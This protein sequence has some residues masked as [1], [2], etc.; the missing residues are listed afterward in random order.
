MI[1]RRQQAAAVRQSAVRP[2][3]SGC[4]S[5]GAVQI[6]FRTRGAVPHRIVGEPGNGP[7]IINRDPAQQVVRCS[8]GVSG[9]LGG[10]PPPPPPRRCVPHMILNHRS[11]SPCPRG[12]LIRTS[13]SRNAARG[14]VGLEP[15]STPTHGSH[16]RP[17]RAGPS[18]ADANH[19][20]ILVS[21][22]QPEIVSNDS[23]IQALRRRNSGPCQCIRRYGRAVTNFHHRGS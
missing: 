11:P 15:R 20:A 10:R 7:R 16:C 13:L 17:P 14:R 21:G 8:T 18:P 12:L 6:R 23:Q 3:P 1:L 22:L 19:T 2:A 4:R 9:H 5:S